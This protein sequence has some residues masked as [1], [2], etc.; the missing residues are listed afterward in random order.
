MKSNFTVISKPNLFSTFINNLS[1]MKKWIF[2]LFVGITL[3]SC[4]FHEPEFRGEEKFKFDKINGQNVSFTASAKVYNG[5]WFGVKLKP[6]SLDLYA[7]GK[8]M[9]KIYLDKKVK[10]KAKRETN[11]EALLHAELEKGA[12]IKIMGLMTKNEVSVRLAGKVKGGVFIFSKKFE[13]DE[14]KMVNPRSMKG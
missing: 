4:T 7:D 13:I 10:L 5:N 8:Y 3:S 6:S 9:G 12:M 11:L 14:T 1:R 2:I